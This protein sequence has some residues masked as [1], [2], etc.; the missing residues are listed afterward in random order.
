MDQNKLLR[1]SNELTQTEPS[2]L[3]LRESTLLNELDLTATNAKAVIE[4]RIGKEFLRALAE[5]P[6]EAIE[7][8]F[9]G[10]RD[11]SPFF[12]AI[13]DIRELCA[14][15]V[16]QQAQE[17]RETEQ[18]QQQAE[19]DRA[20]ASGE[21]IGWPEVLKKFSEIHGRDSAAKLL[22]KM[23][24]APRKE[25]IITPEQRAIALQQAETVKKLY[26]SKK[27]SSEG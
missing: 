3:T 16:R 25:I 19:I 5:F 17:Q 23:P 2:S 27:V 11:V 4:P 10:W 14:A 26:G 1:Q 7:A 21:L 6:A 12:P 13:S 18:A 15:W 20:R 24:E 22:K 8:A 9:R